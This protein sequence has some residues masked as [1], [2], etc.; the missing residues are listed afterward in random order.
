MYPRT[1]AE[2]KR[3]AR[4]LKSDAQRPKGAKIVVCPPALYIAPLIAVFGK[5]KITLG[6]QN[7]FFADEGAF[8]GEVSPVA[9]KS[10][11]ARYVIL[12]HSERRALGE[13]NDVIAKKC[14]AAIGAGLSVILCIGEKERDEAGSYFTE[15]GTA[16]R[17]SLAAFPAKHVSR[18]V[19]AYEP[20]WAIGAKALR[21]ATADDFREMQLL[22]RRNLVGRFGKK[23][24]FAVPILYG[25][26]VD[27]NNASSFFA[28]G[29]DG[30]LVGRASLDP[31]KFAAIVS[32]AHTHLSL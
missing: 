21:A 4:A 5:A 3:I 27:D 16:L 23:R 10:L 19:I 30:L 14:I 8:T 22:I 11:G 26:S 18:L 29:A 6:G 2:A 31:K 9:L 15:V 1:L 28:V 32:S 24:G 20:I 12:G 25:G 17:E 7:A 13:T